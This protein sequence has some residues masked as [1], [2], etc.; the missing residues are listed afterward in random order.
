LLPEEEPLLRTVELLLPEVLPLLRE[1]ELPVEE[2]PVER[3]RLSCCAVVP[4]ERLLPEEPVLPE[5]ERTCEEEEEPELR[6]E[7][8]P[9]EV[10]P[11]L[12]ELLWL[13]VDRVEPPPVERVWATISGAMSMARAIIMETAYVIILL[14]ASQ[15]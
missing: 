4:E 14:I 5:E 2:L 6:V 1:L 10:L 9:E 8:L 7:E 15:I 13:E 11:L 3:L 12:R